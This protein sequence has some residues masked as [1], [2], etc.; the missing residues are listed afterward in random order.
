MTA[1][2]TS[3]LLD[4]FLPDPVF[5]ASSERVIAE[6]LELGGVVVAEPVYAELA[7]SFA[8]ITQLE[9]VLAGATIGVEPLGRDAAFL[10]GR[11]FRAY[12]DGGGRRERV[13]TD[14][15]IG[16]HAQAHRLR[17]VTRDRGFYR[18]YFDG[19]IVVDPQS[20]DPAQVP[21]RD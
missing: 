10:S 19:L 16:A 7:A 13:I 14:F 18:Q 17:L 3:V 4:V 21:G 1:L 11:L 12:R 5:A 15:L 20:S 9:E 2:D 8:S 6:A